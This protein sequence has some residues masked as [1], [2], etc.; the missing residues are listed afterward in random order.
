M[1]NMN[2]GFDLKVW[3][4]NNHLT[5]K[6][7]ADR[8]SYSVSRISH[9]EFGNVSLSN[10]LIQ[11]V[12][13]LDMLLHPH[14]KKDPISEKWDSIKYYSNIYGDEISVIEEEIIKLLTINVNKMGLDNTEAYLKFIGSAFTNLAQIN[15]VSFSDNDEGKKPALKLFN[16]TYREA[17]VYLRKLHAK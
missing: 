8:I 11:Q 3:R 14:I 9:I 4:K 1:E 13:K 6:E 10:K 2:T 12:E 7:L 17:L 15:T 5:Q 16:N